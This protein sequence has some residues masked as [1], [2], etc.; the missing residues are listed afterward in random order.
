MERY[1]RQI[2]SIHL[3]TKHYLLIAEE[4]GECT[5]I[6][7]LKEHRDAYDHIVR[8]YGVEFSDKEIDNLKQYK[9]DN[10]KKALGHEYRAFFDTADWLA[11]VCRK[12]IRELL[13]GKERDDIIEAL[14]EYLT[15]KEKLIS[16]PIKI[17]ELRERKDIG[18]ANGMLS[19]VREYRDI[20][21]D[22]LDSYY[23][24]HDVFG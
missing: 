15:M 12:R 19:E 5:F 22:L 20:L 23:K 14:P 1:W 16:Y 8:I 9:V 17:A 13:A 24:V 6:Q 10:M 2:S 4:M 3:L 21:D 7:P 18:D 11:L